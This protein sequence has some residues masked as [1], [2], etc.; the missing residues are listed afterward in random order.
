MKKRSA[1]RAIAY[2]AAA[3]V[4]LGIWGTAEHRRAQNAER[5]VRYQGEYAFAA[6]CEA[7]ENMDAAL[8]KSRYALDGGMTAALCAEAYARALSASAALSHLSFPV[9]ELEETAAFLARTGDYT[10]YLLR[11]AGG[12]E[13][14]SREERE[15]LRSLGDAAAV[16]SDNLC[17]LRMDVQAGLVSPDGLSEELPALSD[18]FL[19]MEQEFPELPTMVYDGPFSSAVAERTPRMTRNAEAIGKEQ[20]ALIAAGFLGVRSNTAE[21][22]G[23]VE[24]KLPAWRVRLGDATVCV[25]RQGGFITEALVSR[26]PSRESLSIEQ[27]VEAAERILWDHGYRNMK[28]SYHLAQD[29]AL[30]VTFCALE[31]E[32]ICYPDM[33]KVTVALDDGSLLRF[34][35]REYL[36]SH[37]KRQLPAPET[38]SGALRASLPEEL[39]VLSERLAVIPTAGA[40]EL[41][42]REFICENP[43]GQHYLVYFNAVTGRQEKI[44][45]LLEDENGTL[46]M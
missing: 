46:S 6:L 16:L 34:D 4:C 5:T 40:E 13:E 24:G 33:V 27:G 1:I 32:T 21:V 29:G 2:L 20:A 15:N 8:E 45:I 39:T 30:T 36:T 28:E 14:L 19:A 3:A 12:G 43:D 18:S 26:I 41:F 7:V 11:K 42:C 25:S 44:L 35:A 22:E 9:Q 37:E 38:D 31:G 17:S 23:A 10:A